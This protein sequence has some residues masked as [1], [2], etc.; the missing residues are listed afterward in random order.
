MKKSII[1]VAA[2]LMTLVANADNTY[3]YL[4][5][6]NHNKA[7]RSFLAEGLTITFSDGKAFVSQNGQETS[8]PLADLEKMYF[9]SVPANVSSVKSHEDEILTVMNLAGQ[10]V[11]T[12][13]SQKE[14]NGNLKKGIYLVKAIGKTMKIEVK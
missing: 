13:K 8:L 11:A 3:A 7:E 1:F 12:F 6:S 14:I 2:C 10:R 5:F 9:S 4:T